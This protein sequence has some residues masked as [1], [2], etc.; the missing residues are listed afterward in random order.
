LNLSSSVVWKS[1][2]LVPH[3]RGEYMELIFFM[4]GELT[5]ESRGDI[6]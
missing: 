3:G 5:T 6:K 4:T 2:R 1:T